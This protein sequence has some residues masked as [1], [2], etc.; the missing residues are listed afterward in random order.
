VQKYLIDKLQNKNFK[1]FF[2]FF[3]LQGNPA[4]LVPWMVH[5]IF[6]LIAITILSIVTATTYFAAGVTVVGA[7]Y[8]IV[9]VINLRK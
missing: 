1:T 3:S 4:L 2:D 7:A 5:T 6:S 8:I 9:A